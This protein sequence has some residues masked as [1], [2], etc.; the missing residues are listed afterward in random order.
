MVPQVLMVLWAMATL[1]LAGPGTVLEASALTEAD[2]R[3]CH[4]GGTYGSVSNQHHQVALQKGIDCYT[5]CHK[6]VKDPVT[7][8]LTMQMVRDC[9]VCHG[10]YDHSLAHN[11]LSTAPDCG[12][13]HT[14]PPVAEHKSICATCHSST[15][16]EVIN[17][18]NIGKGPTG[19]PV[20]CT[21]C[22]AGVNHILQ[23]DK[24]IPSVECVT[25]HAQGVVYEHLN[26]TSTC[27]T[28]HQSTKPAV[29]QAIA[30]GRAGTTVNCVSCHGALNHVQQHDMVSTPVD[31]SSC[32]NQGPVYEHTNRT[33][34]CA[35][36]HSSTNPT[37]QQTIT[38]G[39]AGTPVSCANCHG[40]VN[41]VLDHNKALANADCAQC[42]NLGVVNEHLSR[43]STCATCH[44]STNQTV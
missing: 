40:Q 32:H 7:G 21:N 42:H 16:P 14:Q 38:T 11:M 27:A 15:K 19:I 34:T 18:I 41:H 36:C 5:S 8:I 2:C 29:I 25:C 10:Q 23:H 24:A 44:N 30:A 3:T 17:T 43:T 31:C 28:C 12:Q 13:C 1:L 4:T 37:V 35:T 39:K 33:S 26:R 6:L 9:I 20:N 22:H